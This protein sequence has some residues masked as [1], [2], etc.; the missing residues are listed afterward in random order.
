MS[1]ESNEITETGSNGFTRRNALKAGVAVGVGAAAWSG[2]T[3]T[4]LG[5]TPAYAQAGCT[6]VINVNLSGGCR[7]TDEGSA[8]NCTTGT[9]GYHPLTSSNPQFV[10]GTAA[11]PNI[12]EHTCCDKNSVVE[13]T[14]PSNLQCNVV[15]IGY[16]SDGTCMKGTPIEDGPFSLGTGSGGSVLVTLGCEPGFTSSTHYTI[17]AKCNSIGA[18]PGCISTS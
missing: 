6:G 1:D 4:S 14:F 3:I 8:S 10:V 13:V 2:A 18:P 12:P 9:Y 5:G 15:I 16:S 11:H 17:T 7:N